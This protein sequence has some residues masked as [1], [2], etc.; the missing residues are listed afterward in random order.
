MLYLMT[1]LLDGSTR[2]GF[3]SLEIQS[4]DFAPQHQSVPLLSVE[5]KVSL[6]RS[7]LD[8]EYESGQA[9]CRAAMTRITETFV[10]D[11]RIA[12]GDVSAEVMALVSKNSLASALDAEGPL[13]KW[14]REV[15]FGISPSKYVHRS[16]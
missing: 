5:S 14:H 7:L 1:M 4:V 16:G 11:L 13:V 2:I 6:I 8:G 15:G 10:G 3:E 12:C 9:F